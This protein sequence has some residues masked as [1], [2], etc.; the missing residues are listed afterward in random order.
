MNTYPTGT[1][2]AD[3]VTTGNFVAGTQAGTIRLKNIGA[4]DAA[5]F[6]TI[7]VAMTG[8]GYVKIVGSTTQGRNFVVPNEDELDLE[9]YADGTSGPGTITMKTEAGASF[10]KTYSPPP[11]QAA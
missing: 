3:S 4:T 11:S 1:V 9:I 2:L 6:D 7:T 5:A 8:V 10:V